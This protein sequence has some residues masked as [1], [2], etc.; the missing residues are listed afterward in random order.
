MIGK[1]SIYNPSIFVEIMTGKRVTKSYQ[2]QLEFIEIYC[3]YAHIAGTVRKSRILQRAI[4]FLKQ[5]VPP[6][7]LT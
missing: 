2:Q 6:A 5:Y 1:E 7:R 3:K 4:D